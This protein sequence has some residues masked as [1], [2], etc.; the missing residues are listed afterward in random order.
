M[1]SGPSPTFTIAFFPDDF[2]SNKL[3]IKVSAAG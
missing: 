1:S 3:P 2:Y